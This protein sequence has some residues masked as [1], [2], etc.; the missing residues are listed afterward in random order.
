LSTADRIPG[1]GQLWTSGRINAAAAVADTC[2]AAAPASRSANPL[3]DLVRVTIDPAGAG[4][5]RITMDA[6]AGHTLQQV[7]WSVPAN[8]VAEA[9]N[10]CGL[11]TGVIL[12]AGTQSFSFYL[13][14]LSGEAVTLPALVTG[15]F[16]TWRTF[17]GGGRDAW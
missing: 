1:T 15:S 4:R 3:A 13:R 5:L 8:A 10:G 6:P 9:P 11:P 14:R 2:G 7:S 16:G 12:P 17:I